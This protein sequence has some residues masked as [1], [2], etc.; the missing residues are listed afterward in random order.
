MLRSRPEFKAKL[1][2]NVNALQN[3][4]KDRGFD[5]GTTKVLHPFILKEYSRSDGVSQRP[6]RKSRYFVL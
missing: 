3:G 2:E 6:K 1:W 4:L 5:I